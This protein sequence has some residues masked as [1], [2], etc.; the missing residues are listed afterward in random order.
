MVHT[1]QT[2]TIAE[3]RAIRDEILHAAAVRGAH[4]VRVFG[5]VA[6]NQ[7]R[8]TSDV[9]FL[10]EMEPGRTALDISELILDL[11]EILHRD[12]DVVVTRRS[13]SLAEEIEREAIPL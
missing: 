9:D 12:V 13:T 3:L 6:R 11:E 1:Q 5:S 8:P 7:S 4:N 2:I 10:V